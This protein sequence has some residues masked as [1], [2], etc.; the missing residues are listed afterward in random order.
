LDELVAKIIKISD[1]CNSAIVQANN[2]SLVTSVDAFSSNVA[3]MIFEQRPEWERHA[4]KEYDDD[5]SLVITL[6]GVPA[7]CHH[8]LAVSTFGEEITVF[9]SNA[10]IHLGPY[11]PSTCGLDHAIARALSLMDDIMA[12]KIVAV[13]RRVR[14]IQLPVYGLEN[15]ERATSG[16]M[17]R[18]TKVRSWNGTFDRG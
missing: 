1:L 13:T 9:F 10:H 6:R 2:M 3:K 12:G 17:T 5:R 8:D 14:L 16:L 18:V 11:E 4:S 15:R 7:D